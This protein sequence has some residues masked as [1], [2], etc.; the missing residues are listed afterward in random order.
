[1]SDRNA[2]DQLR[3]NLMSLYAARNYSAALELVERNEPKFPEMAA[4][5]TFWKICL[6]SLEGRLEQ[7]LSTFRQGLQDGL[8]WAE[9]QFIDTDLDPLRDL[10]EFKELV[11]ESVQHWDEGRK[12]INREYILLLPDAPSPAPYPLIIVLHGHNGDKEADLEH[13]D[14]ARRLGWAVLSAQST[15]LLYP[16]GHCWDDP[17]AG[18]QDI[19]FYLEHILETSN[20]DRERILIGGFSQ[21]SGMAIYAALSGAI[22]VCGF[23]TSAAWWQ[24][25]ASL[26]TLAVNAK[27]VRGYFVSG[28]KDHTLGRAREIQDVLKQ[29][30]VPFAEELHPGLGHAF[31]PDFDKS[32]TSALE[33]IFRE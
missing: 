12:Q 13:W 14:V 17:D 10:P 26:T 2:F 28:E 19:L 16:G 1:M 29:N 32:F 20:I 9:S 31:P 30:N 6:L 18:L 21:G 25:I 27:N 8:W 24:D 11:A 23:V 15:Q 5:T 3:Q 22:P 33:F 7:A 4:R